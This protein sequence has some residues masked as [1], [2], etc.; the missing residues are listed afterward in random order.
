M[1][2]TY[3]ICSTGIL[4]KFAAQLDTTMD[5]GN[6]DTGSMRVADPT[7]NNQSVATATVLA[8]P[9]QAYTVCMGI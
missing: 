6:T 4:G 9:G 1:S 5:D 7:N 3:I 2:G 8:N